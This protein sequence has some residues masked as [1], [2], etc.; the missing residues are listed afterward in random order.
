MLELSYRPQ[1][2]YDFY[3]GE[4]VVI[5][6]A[7]IEW[8]WDVDVRVAISSHLVLIKKSVVKIQPSEAAIQGRFEK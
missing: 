7:L 6:R 8:G 2:F 1:V 3:R 5:D 4:A